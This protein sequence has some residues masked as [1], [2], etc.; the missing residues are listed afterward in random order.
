MLN[1]SE[2]DQWCQK[3]GLS[4]VARREIE[5][6][7]SSPPARRVKSGPYNVK[8]HFNQS[9]KMNHTIQF[10]SRTVEYP[11]I[12]KMEYFDGDVLEMWDQPP[13]FNLLYKGPKGT[14]IGHIYTADFFVLRKSS[15]G[16]EEWKP[17]KELVRLAAKNPER[18]YKDQDGKWRCPPCESYAAQFP[19][20]YFRVCSSTDINWVLIRNLKLFRPFF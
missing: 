15:A 4:D 19:P 8:G 5:R 14:N 1:D 17:E 20:L 12:L 13:S 2:F 18:Y 3:L 7:R 16:W 9:Q 11:A 6:I 10:E